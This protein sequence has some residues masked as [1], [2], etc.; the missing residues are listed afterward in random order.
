MT[1]GIIYD[2]IFLHAG[3]WSSASTEKYEPTG[4][5]SMLRVNNVPVLQ[6]SPPAITPPHRIIRRAPTTVDIQQGAP[7]QPASGSVADQPVLRSKAKKMS[8]RKSKKSKR[9]VATPQF[10]Q[11]PLPEQSTQPPDATSKLPVHSK[12]AAAK[13]SAAKPPVQE[14]PAVATGPHVYEQDMANT[15]KTGPD[16]EDTQ[17]AQPPD[18]ETQEGGEPQ[19]PW[20]HNAHVTTA[21]DDMSP[22]PPAK[23]ADQ[24]AQDRETASANNLKRSTTARQSTPT[25]TPGATPRENP[26]DTS[27]E[28]ALDAEVKKEPVIAP[29]Q[30]VA[31]TPAPAA[32]VIPAGAPPAIA[33]TTPGS[34]EAPPAVAAPKQKKEK[35][36]AQKAAHARYMR[37][38][39]SFTRTFN[40]IKNNGHESLTVY[41]ITYR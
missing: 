39:R 31:V 5:G 35:T 15:T 28:N 29:A 40:Y 20:D 41:H 4:S 11:Q 25:P 22:D 32:P 13:K 17:E 1:Y 21:K 34:T 19:E 23:T 24:V 6:S 38:S 26:G 10:S 8:V 18:D 14:P 33:A 2:D 7:E 9:P 3:T 36:P 30:P 12:L 16:N 27:L 37:F